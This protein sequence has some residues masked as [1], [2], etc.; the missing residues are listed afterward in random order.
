LIPILQHFHGARVYVDN[1]NYIYFNYTII[2]I[3]YRSNCTFR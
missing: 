1:N 3:T 2:N